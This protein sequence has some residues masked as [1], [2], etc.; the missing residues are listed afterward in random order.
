MMIDLESLNLSVSELHLPRE[1]CLHCLFLYAF[2]GL[3]KVGYW[4]LPGVS[5]CA[6]I[7]AR[8]NDLSPNESL[9]L[10]FQHSST[11]SDSTIVFTDDSKFD[12]DVGHDVMFPSLCMRGSLPGVASVFTVERSAIVLSL[13]IIF[14][15]PVSF[16]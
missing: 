12:A 11:H 4:Q 5:V 7:I 1:P 10:F 6:L 8:K 9:S 3:L 16:L 2:L 13:R 14:T 15:F